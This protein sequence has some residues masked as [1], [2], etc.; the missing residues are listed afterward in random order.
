MF[1]GLLFL[2]SAMLYKRH[3]Y[4]SKFA[5]QCTVSF[6]YLSNSPT[7]FFLV[8]LRASDSEDLLFNE[9]SPRVSG[10]LFCLTC[11]SGACCIGPLFGLAVPGTDSTE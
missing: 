8:S 11:L 6:F 1:D 2:V 10:R 4:V 5:L 3:T 7:T 9:W